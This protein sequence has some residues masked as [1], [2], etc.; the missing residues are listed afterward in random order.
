[1]GCVRQQD[2]TQ[3]VLKHLRRYR[4]KGLTSF[5]AFGLYQI[6]RLADVIYRLRDREIEIETELRTG[7][8]TR[9]AIYRL[10]K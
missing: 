7:N 10:A 8:G 9:Y 2:Q 1:M 4:R 5:Q 6:T 3:V